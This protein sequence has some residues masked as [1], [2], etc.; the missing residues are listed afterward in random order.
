MGDEPYYTDDPFD[1]EPDLSTSGIENLWIIEKAQKIC[2]RPSH[3]FHSPKEK[4]KWIKIDGQY[5][6]GVIGELWLEHCLSW[7]E[8][9]NKERL[10]IIMPALANYILNKARMTDW[11]ATRKTEEEWEPTTEERDLADDGF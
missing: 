3:P 7:A 11:N 5:S 9:K 1:E 2:R 10:I 8:Y 4:R 6:R